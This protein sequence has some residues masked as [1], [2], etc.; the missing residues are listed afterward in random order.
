MQFIAKGEANNVLNA[1]IGDFHPHLRTFSK[2]GW[3]DSDTFYEYLNHIKSQFNDDEDIHIILDQLFAHK[4]EEILEAARDL[5][6]ILH[7]IPSGL[8]DLYQPLD[9]KLFVII[10]AYLKHMMTVFKR[11]AYH[12]Q[13]FGLSMYG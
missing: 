12:D 8:T 11:G 4:C 1:Q 13:T 9:V 10:K 7:F 6:I 5:G 3:T 2:K